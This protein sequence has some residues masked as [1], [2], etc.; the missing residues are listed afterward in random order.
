MILKDNEILRCPKCGGKIFY[1][2]AH[3]T[4]DWEIDDNGMFVQCINDCT[5][6]THEPDKEDILECKSCGYSD[7]GKNFLEVTKK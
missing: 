7:T 3:V 6:V 4:Q 2:T 1:A 5:E